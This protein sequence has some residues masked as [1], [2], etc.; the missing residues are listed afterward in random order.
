M[1]LPHVLAFNA[2]AAPEAMER[3]CRALRTDYPSDGL[4]DLARSLGA[5]AALRDLGMPEAGI[6][7]VVETVL[8]DPPWNPRA[9]EAEPLHE[10]LKRAW[11]GERPAAPH[12]H[13]V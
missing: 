5:P 7:P 9:M 12:K 2:P 8:A 13:W 3:L 6:Q 1:V 11:A 10:L 4:F